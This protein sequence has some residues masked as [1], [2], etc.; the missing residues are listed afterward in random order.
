M[1][2][3]REWLKQMDLSLKSE[4]VPGV[5]SQRGASDA[6]EELERIDNF[7]RNLRARRCAYLSLTVTAVKQTYLSCDY[8]VTVSQGTPL[9]VCARRPSPCPK[10][11]WVQEQKSEWRASSRWSTRPC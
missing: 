5:E 3:I 9:K 4:N 11:A 6:A 2:G 1:D 8:V 10:Q 7:Y